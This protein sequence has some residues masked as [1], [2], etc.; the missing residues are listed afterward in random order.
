MGLKLKNKQVRIPYFIGLAWFISHPIVSVITGELK[1][2]G[3]YVD[4]HQLDIPSLQTEPYELDQIRRN[5]LLEDTTSSSEGDEKFSN[6][7]DVLEYMKVNYSR[8][9]RDFRKIENE[10]KKHNTP[11]GVEIKEDEDEE[12]HEINPYQT[13]YISCNNVLHQVSDD[14]VPSTY[15]DYSV[16]RIDPSQSPLQAVEALVIVLPHSSNWF[17]SDFHSSMLTFIEHMVQSPWMAKSILIVSP[18]EKYSN[19]NNNYSSAS[20]T[21]SHLVNEYTSNMLV[22][23]DVVKQFINDFYSSQ[24]SLPID[25]KSLIVRQLI[26]IE[27]DASPRY[28]GDKFFVLPQGRNGLVPN[29]DLL[30]A[31]R[32]ALLKVFGGKVQILMHL[33]DLTW[34]DDL[35]KLRLPADKF[36]QNWTKDFGNMIGFMAAFWR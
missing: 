29:L 1:C 3:M 24:S 30:S 18:N 19:I 14:D 34:W 22:D 13:P 12:R 36:H 31:V 35:I 15:N 8:I 6:A 10:K 16:I 32:L 2:R 7:C 28:S 4:E 9:Q 11:K 17:K 20:G 25:T 26:A 27:I 5:Y 33:H 23:P 21:G